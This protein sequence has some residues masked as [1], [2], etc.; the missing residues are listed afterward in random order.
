MSPKESLKKILEEAD[1][2]S[3]ERES[4]ANVLGMLVSHSTAMN[5]H[6]PPA[7]YEQ[8]LLRI[9]RTRISTPKKSIFTNFQDWLRLPELSWSLAG[10]F[11]ALLVVM[12]VGYHRLQNR[13]S[14]SLSVA[15]SSNEKD[16]LASTAERG[17]EN[18]VNHWIAS[19]GDGAQRL[20]VADQDLQ[21]LARELAA[22]RD[23]RVVDKAL[24][25]VAAAMGMK[26]L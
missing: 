21:G 13:V 17:G 24:A 5:R 23:P 6:E 7:G 11:A 16:L 18:L 1:F 12:L 20:S 2:P 25:E 4:A 8:Q 10:T 26:K 14:D 15:Q 22:Q 19:T 3:S 9:L